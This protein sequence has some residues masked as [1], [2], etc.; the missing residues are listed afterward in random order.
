MASE[1]GGESKQGKTGKA[2]FGG[3]VAG[4]RWEISLINQFSKT[5]QPR[6]LTTQGLREKKEGEKEGNNNNN[7]TLRLLL[8][9]TTRRVLRRAQLASCALLVR[10]ISGLCETPLILFLLLR[11][12]CMHLARIQL[13]NY[14]IGASRPISL[15]FR[16]KILSSSALRIAF[17]VSALCAERRCG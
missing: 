4:R 9:P 15:S 8:G 1:R 11:V 6:L 2:R 16:R 10:P 7:K 3:S 5:N 12:H 17:I 14:C 13:C